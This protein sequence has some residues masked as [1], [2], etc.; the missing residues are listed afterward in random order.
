M[1]FRK[2]RKVKIWET[3]K[4]QDLGLRI[5]LAVEGEGIGR[6]LDTGIE[7]AMISFLRIGRNLNLKEILVKRGSDQVFE[8]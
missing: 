2:W 6:S 4:K 3:F 8:N 5:L 1:R 7:G